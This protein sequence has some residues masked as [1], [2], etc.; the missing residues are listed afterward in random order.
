LDHPNLVKLYGVA[1][2]PL[3]MVLELCTG[4]PPDLCRMIRIAD[5]DGSISAI[6][7]AQ[8][9]WRLRLSIAL[10]IARGMKFLHTLTPPIVHRGT[11]AHRRY[12]KR[13]TELIV[14]LAGFRLAESQRIPFNKW[15]QSDCQG[16]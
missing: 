5:S 9:P 3:A 11:C 15:L 13:A 6:P 4:D 1:L 8:F 14:S 7:F 2:K 10:D 12:G 16:G